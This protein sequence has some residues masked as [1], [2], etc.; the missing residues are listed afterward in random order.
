MVV[1]LLIR[2]SECLGPALAGEALGLC[3]VYEEAVEHMDETSSHHLTKQESIAQT[4]AGSSVQG[5]HHSASF[6]SLSLLNARLVLSFYTSLVR[7]LACCAPSPTRGPA[8]PSPAPSQLGA[9][10]QQHSNA[11]RTL[12]ILQNMVKVEEIV[13]ILSIPF[14]TDSHKGLLPTHKEAALL[15]LDRVYHMMPQELLLR[16]LT[17]AFLPDIKMT[18]GLTEVSLHILFTISGLGWIVSTSQNETHHLIQPAGY[19]MQPFPS[20]F[21]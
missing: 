13:G 17:D 7:L 1:R 16:L 6:L 20:L 5:L 9:F 19:L 14:S 12:S 15:F 21:R 3:R 11:E 4:A 8:Q 10:K 18:L 2:N